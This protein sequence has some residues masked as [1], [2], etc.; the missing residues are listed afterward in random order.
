M[1]ELQISLLK[2]NVTLKISSKSFRHII[3][4]RHFVAVLSLAPPLTIKQARRR[5]KNQQIDS[6][7]SLI[8]RRFFSF[9]FCRQLGKLKLRYVRIVLGKMFYFKDN[10]FALFSAE[11]GADIETFSCHNKHGIRKALLRNHHFPSVLC[12]F[13]VARRKRIA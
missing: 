4:S 10:T 11:A 13:I 7:S 9:G 5:R 3:Q 1:D 12:F 6:L 2:L 8:C